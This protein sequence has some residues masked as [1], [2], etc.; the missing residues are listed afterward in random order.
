MNRP[1]NVSL[2][3][4]VERR[5]PTGF[6]I[7]EQLGAGATSWVYRA[8]RPVADSA[9]REPVA[10]AEAGPSPASGEEIVVKVMHPG[11]VRGDTVERFLREMEILQKLQHP[12]I[13]PLLQPGEAT[14]RS[15]SPCRT[16]AASRSATACSASRRCRCSTR[17]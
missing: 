8:S 13:V 14:G 4:A 9:A 6:S 15:S 17:W 5:L 10:R 12:H 16:C 7:R 2:L 3:Q 1:I 11:T